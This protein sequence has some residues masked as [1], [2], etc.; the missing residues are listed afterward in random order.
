MT[1]QPP[2]KLAQPQGSRYLHLSVG[3]IAAGG[4]TGHMTVATLSG[5][6]PARALTRMEWT[7]PTPTTRP[8]ACP[9]P[10]QMPSGPPA[11]PAHGPRRP[12]RRQHDQ[13]PRPRTPA[14]HRL[15]N[16]CSYQQ[17]PTALSAPDRPVAVTG[18]PP[19]V[20][21]R[22]GHAQGKVQMPL[23]FRPLC[24]CG[25][26]YRSASACFCVA[27]PLTLVPWGRGLAHHTDM[28]QV[29]K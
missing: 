12:T 17:G 19:E 26:R 13:G 23:L 6:L 10:G 29:H 8:S 27:A 3:C 11:H 2:Q 18:M 16:S 22:F 28:E 14:R 21:D 24:R 25:R 7:A 15:E 20:D 4:A 5:Q 9:V 1:Y